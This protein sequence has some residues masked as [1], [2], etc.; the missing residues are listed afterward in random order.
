MQPSHQRDQCS[1]N[2]QAARRARW[3]AR[4]QPANCSLCCPDQH[5]R[6]TTQWKKQFERNVGSNSMV[7]SLEYR[8][9]SADSEQAIEDVW[10]YSLSA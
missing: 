4:S 9:R 1:Q 10:A 3:S 7:D 5:R 8:T 6:V 2:P